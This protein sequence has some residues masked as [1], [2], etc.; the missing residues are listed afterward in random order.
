MRMKGFTFVEILIAV[1]IFLILMLAAYTVMD[2]GRNAWFTGEASGQLRQEIIRP[3]MRMETELKETSPAQINLTIGNSSSSLTFKIP[4]DVDLDGSTLDS[5]GNIEWSGN[6]TYSLDL[7][8]N[9]IKRTVSGTTTILANDIVFL[10]FTRPLSSA[11]R[12]QIDITA[13]KM[14]P[15]RRVFQEAGQIII[16]MRN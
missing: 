9:Q 14:S 4:Q 8:S 10:L 7:A 11:A 2:V 13:R 12:L 16:K 5:A 1:T 15:I 6:I 3:F